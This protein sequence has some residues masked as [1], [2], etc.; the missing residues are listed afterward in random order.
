M[1]ATSRE[2][3]SSLNKSIHTS[4]NLLITHF[5]TKQRSNLS[6]VLINECTCSTEICLNILNTALLYLSRWGNSFMLQTFMCLRSTNLLTQFQIQ[7]FEKNRRRSLPQD[8]KRRL[9][10]SRAASLLR[11]LSIR[12]QSEFVL[13]IFLFSNLNLKE[14]RWIK[15]LSTKAW[16]TLSTFRAEP[17]AKLGR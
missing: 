5:L 7:L 11:I 4:S 17:R 13:S 1:K 14:R 12:L 2:E 10:H 16:M 15:K 3:L 9:H 6:I 8:K